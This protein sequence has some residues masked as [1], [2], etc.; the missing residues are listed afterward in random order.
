MQ[1]NVIMLEKQLEPAW[2][3]HDYCPTLFNDGR[4][5]YLRWE[6]TDLPHVWGK[7]DPPV[8][9]AAKTATTTFRT[10][11]H[12]DSLENATDCNGLQR[13]QGTL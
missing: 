2:P 5:L 10:D 9:L 1:S 6:Y 13:I 3:D 12:Q 11:Y 8:V 7:V 4:I